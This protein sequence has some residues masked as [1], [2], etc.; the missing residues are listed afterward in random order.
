[1]LPSTSVAFALSLSACIALAYGLAFFGL[2]LQFRRAEVLAFARAWLALGFVSVLGPLIVLSD[3]GHL[4]HGG[5]L[6]V[7]LAIAGVTMVVAT[8]WFYL[9]AAFVRVQAARQRKWL[10]MSFPCV[11]AAFFAL[12][13][14]QASA[15]I[16]SSGPKILALT[17]TVVALV[18][19]WRA[20]TNAG[21]RSLIA[22]QGLVA[23]RFASGLIHDVFADSS[24]A[25][26]QP[27]TI[28]AFQLATTMFGGF[29]TTVAI[30]AS[31][32][33]VSIKN[34]VAFEREL[35]RSQ[36]MESLGRMANGVAHDFNNILAIMV[37]ASEVGLVEEASAQDRKIARDSVQRAAESGKALT[38]LLLTFARPNVAD[39]ANFAPLPRIVQLVPLM[40]QLVGK[41]V[42]ID[43]SIDACGIASDCLVSG[44]ATHFDQ[45]LLNLAANSRDAMPEGGQIKI[46][47]EIEWQTHRT[48][49]SGTQGVRLKLQFRDTGT[50]LSEETKDRIFEPFYTT[51][52]EGQGNGLGLASAAAYVRH[53][54]GTIEVQNNIGPGA[55]FVIILPIVGEVSVARPTSDT[56][57]A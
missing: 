9:D 6:P 45:M 43:C 1:V 54:G 13:F 5:S 41:S 35:A 10:W 53:A 39:S 57:K 31:E 18:F 56:S 12:E 40:Q 26:D 29:L 55:T 36:K 38:R 7:W 52:P 37:S 47:A 8:A 49:S 48:L 44:E 16:H 4:A 2:W 25:A 42:K 20:P 19:L 30:F 34:R 24:A 51:K 28:T 11:L 46:H 32:R 23:L 33:E 14:L 22:G 27:W 15:F 50:G 3:L 21:R 17:T